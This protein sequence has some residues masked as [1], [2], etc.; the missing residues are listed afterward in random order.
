MLPNTDDDI[1][2]A[3]IL[4]L[5]VVF[6]GYKFLTSRNKSGVLKHSLSWFFI[7]F[8]LIIGYAFRFEL[9]NIKERVIAVLIP[10][11]KW[12][13][14]KGQFVIARSGDG[15]FYIDVKANG[16]IINFLID[17]GATDIAISKRDAIRLGINPKELNYTRRY[18]TAN[19]VSYAAPIK[20][21]QLTIGGKTFH[22]VEAHVVSGDLGTSLL[23]MSLIQDFNHFRITKDMLILDY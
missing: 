10:S 11:Y 17:T 16:Q 4:F 2:N 6:I 21:K 13:N 9:T 18:K 19:G 7:F 23:G 5:L 15:H 20:I 3:F 8:M 14:E 22:N 12:T 1:L